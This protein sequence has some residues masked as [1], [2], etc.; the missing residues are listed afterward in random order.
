[1]ERLRLTIYLIILI[2]ILKIHKNN[3]FGLQIRLQN[4]ENVF[5]IE[6]SVSSLLQKIVP[7]NKEL[8][9][10]YFAHESKASLPLCLVYTEYL[11]LPFL[12]AAAADHHL[13]MGC[14]RP[15]IKLG[16]CLSLAGDS[17]QSGLFQNIDILSFKCNFLFKKLKTLSPFR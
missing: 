9:K 12:S 4:Q 2:I 13:L 14:H 16:P 5:H 3:N 8:V 10:K 7:C 17:P 6:D 1:M 11:R 15:R